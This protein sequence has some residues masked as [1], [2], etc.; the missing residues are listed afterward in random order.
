MQRAA[1]G[2]LRV[3]GAVVAGIWLLVAV[4]GCDAVER[5]LERRCQ[6]A[7]RDYEDEVIGHTT[8]PRLFADSGARNANRTAQV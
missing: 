4:A 7:E 1:S 6:Q 3:V 5:E 2:H 8:I